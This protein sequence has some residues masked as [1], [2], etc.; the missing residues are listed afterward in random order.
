MN[1]PF[2][3]LTRDQGGRSGIEFTRGT[4]AVKALLSMS[5]GNHG[6][7]MGKVSCCHQGHRTCSSSCSEPHRLCPVSK[8]TQ[9]RGFICCF[10]RHL[11][12]EGCIARVTDRDT[13]SALE[14]ALSGYQTQMQ[15]CTATPMTVRSPTRL[16]GCSV[17][18]GGGDVGD[19]NSAL[20]SG[21][22]AGSPPRK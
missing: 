11:C 15:G 5:R 1:P 17:I 22:H 10:R 18:V 7:R 12:S 13:Q 9:R 20:F 4:G 3:R 19:G 21:C 2:L 8:C 16:R 14:V 6:G